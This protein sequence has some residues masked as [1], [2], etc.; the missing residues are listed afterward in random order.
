[1]NTLQEGLQ[2]KRLGKQI[3]FLREV[4][5]TNSLA[6]ELAGYGA[7][8]GTVVVAEAQRVGRGRKGREWYSPKGGLYFSVVLRPKCDSCEAVKLVFVAGLAVAEVL[9]KKYGLDVAVKWPNDVLANGKKVCGVLSE[10]NLAGEEVNYVVIGIGVNVNVDVIEGFPESLRKVA[11]SLEVELGRKVLLNELFRALLESLDAFYEQFLKE[12][13]VEIL[14][15]WKKYAVFL[16]RQVTVVDEAETLNGLA[17]DI[18]GEGA[19]VLKLGNGALKRVF[20][21]DVS[22]RLN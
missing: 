20:V 1:L 6:K 11:T 8:E 13:T 21:G 4:D 5:S 18:D 15:K 3:I 16:G 7:V 10:M 22:V 9:S 14:C 2:T 17:L 19:L 12:G